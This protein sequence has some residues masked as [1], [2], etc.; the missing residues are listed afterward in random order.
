M[1]DFYNL[2]SWRLPTHDMA[3]LQSH[4]DNIMKRSLIAVLTAAM[5]CVAGCRDATAQP[6]ATKDTQLAPKVA[7]DEPTNDRN[8]FGDFSFSVPKGW[9]IVTPDREKTKAVL[10]LDGTNWQNAK[11]MI[12]VDVGTPTAPTARQLVDGFANSAGGTV[13]AESLDFDGTPGVSASTSSTTLN[14]PRDMTAIYRDGK[15]YLLMAGAVEGV[16][17]SEAV[18]HVRKSWTWTEQKKAE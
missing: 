1:E 4:G 7:S 12:K 10:L 14:T 6:L 5:I 16:E 17:L 15:V 18:S 9:T 13:S 11:A 3:G 2:L 8:N